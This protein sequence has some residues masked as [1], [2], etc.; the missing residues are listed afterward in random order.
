MYSKMSSNNQ[1]IE[2]QREVIALYIKLN[3]QDPRFSHMKDVAWANYF[4]AKYLF[5]DRKQAEGMTSLEN[6]LH[7][8]RNCATKYPEHP[9]A[10]SEFRRFTEAYSGWLKYLENDD[11]PT[12]D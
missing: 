11:I 7:V 3:D 10:E 4:L 1:A 5:K 9:K 6:G 12:T 2:K 8:I